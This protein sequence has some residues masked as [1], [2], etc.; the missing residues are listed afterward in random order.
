MGVERI[1]DAIG[2]ADEDAPTENSRCSLRRRYTW[3][4]EGPFE[5]ELGRGLAGQPRSLRTLEARV[6]RI[7]PT[8]PRGAVWMRGWAWAGCGLCDSRQADCDQ[9]QAH[10]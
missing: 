3:K 1:D 5:F 6:R 2:V 4:S 8:V 10:H 7:G 9:Q